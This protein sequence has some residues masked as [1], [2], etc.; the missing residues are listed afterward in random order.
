MFI[1]TRTKTVGEQLI[2]EILARISDGEPIEYIEL[3]ESEHAQIREAVA[4]LNLSLNQFQAFMSKQS[5]LGI[6]LKVYAD[7]VNLQAAK[8]Q[9]KASKRKKA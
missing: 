5:L 4:K 3:L 8:D 2:E 9:L 7:S 6:P 1:H